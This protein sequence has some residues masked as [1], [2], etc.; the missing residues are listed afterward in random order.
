MKTCSFDNSISYVE[1]EIDFHLSSTLPVKSCKI[2]SLSY[3]SRPKH[4]AVYYLMNS[5]L[6]YYYLFEQK[7]DCNLVTRYYVVSW[8]VGGGS[9]GN[10]K[11]NLAVVPRQHVVVVVGG[12]LRQLMAIIQTTQG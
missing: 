6:F 12:R 2:A 11:V 3:T 10:N 5:I 4:C 1:Q 8:Y 9:W 7:I